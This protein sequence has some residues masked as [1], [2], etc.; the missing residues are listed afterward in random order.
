MCV[1]Q[2]GVQALSTSKKEMKLLLKEGYVDRVVILFMGTTNPA[3]F[4]LHCLLCNTLGTLV[5]ASRQVGVHVL[6]K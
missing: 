4:E 6:S 1:T 3:L 2:V 5:M